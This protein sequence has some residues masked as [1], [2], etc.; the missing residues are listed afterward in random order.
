MST[1]FYGRHYLRD[2]TVDGMITYKLILNKS[3]ARDGDQW[4]ALLN[5]VMNLLVPQEA[6]SFLTNCVTISF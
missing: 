3:G 5:T 6:A 4:W 2:L 1:K